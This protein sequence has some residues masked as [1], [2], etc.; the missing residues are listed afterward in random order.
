MRRRWSHRCVNV[1]AS[2]YKAITVVTGL[3]TVYCKTPSLHLKSSTLT[4]KERNAQTCAPPAPPPPPGM[5]ALR[6][7]SHGPRRAAA[8]RRKVRL[9]LLDLQHEHQAGVLVAEEVEQEDQEVVDDVGLVALPA[10]VHVDGQAGV[11]E[12]EPLDKKGK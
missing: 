11:S 1:G 4:E 10:R 6:S 8:Q 7:L 12:R 2:T 3:T 9:L 5:C